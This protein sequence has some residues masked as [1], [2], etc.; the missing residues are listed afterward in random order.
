MVIQ[1]AGF[2]NVDLRELATGKRVVTH[3]SFVCDFFEDSCALQ[4]AAVALGE[5]CTANDDAEDVPDAVDG[6]REDELPR[7]RKQNASDRY[8]AQ[9]YVTNADGHKEW[10]DVSAFDERCASSENDLEAGPGM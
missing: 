7:R 2:D 9:V 10:V 1:P 5:L 8:E 4:N 6:M 3:V